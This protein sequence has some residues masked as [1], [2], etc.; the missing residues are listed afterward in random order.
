MRSVRAQAEGR[1]M[2]VDL[3][4][5]DSDILSPFK[6]LTFTHKWELGYQK[7]ERGDRINSQGV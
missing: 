6:G 3:V 1:L 2:S 5:P 4:Y 7:R